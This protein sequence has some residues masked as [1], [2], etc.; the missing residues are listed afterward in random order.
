MPVP[1]WWVAEEYLCRFPAFGVFTKSQPNS[2]TCIKRMV[3]CPPFL[4]PRGSE[5]WLVALAFAHSSNGNLT[6]ISRA[7][8]IKAR[9]IIHN[10]AKM[11]RG[12]S[13]ASH[14][15]KKTGGVTR[16]E[17]GA[18]ET[19]FPDE[20]SVAAGVLL[21][22]F[23]ASSAGGWAP[24]EHSHGDFDRC[25][26]EGIGQTWKLVG[27]PPFSALGGSESWLVAP[28]GSAQCATRVATW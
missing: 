7:L 16:V 20:T 10:R 9:K 18:L 13:R 25:A 27:C 26:G 23:A 8:R 12:A 4:A 3:G 22:E 19:L 1:V 24:H 11:A 6:D 14:T 28:Y 2:R 15:P 21:E 17:G 5:S